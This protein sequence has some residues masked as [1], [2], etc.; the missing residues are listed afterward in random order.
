MGRVPSGHDA[1]AVSCV[2]WEE[3]RD[4]RYRTVGRHSSA[5]VRG[6]IWGTID[7]CDGTLTWITRGRVAV[8]EFRRKK[9]IVVRAGKPGPLGTTHLTRAPE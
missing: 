7:R 1:A 3:T 8:R 9:T 6:T 4:G 5:T 2:P